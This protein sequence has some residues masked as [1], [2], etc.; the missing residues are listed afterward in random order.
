MMKELEV[1]NNKNTN[2][3]MQVAL[4]VIFMKI[5]TKKGIKLFCE[6]AT[7]AMIEHLKNYTKG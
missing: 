3:Y 6:M 1:T 4:N 2:A 7:D 5:N